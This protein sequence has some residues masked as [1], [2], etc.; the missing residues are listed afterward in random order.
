MA[1]IHSS[2]FGP[3]ETRFADKMRQTL[4][5][6]LRGVDGELNDLKTLA[7]DV[8]EGRAPYS[9]LEAAVAVWT[10]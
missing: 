2:S 1:P 8:I 5:D 7:T 10:S 6:R 4:P 9:E 3:A